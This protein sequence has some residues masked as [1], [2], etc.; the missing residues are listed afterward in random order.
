MKKQLRTQKPG[1]IPG[2]GFNHTEPAQPANHEAEKERQSTT[3]DATAKWISIAASVRMDIRRADHDY[4]DIADGERMLRKEITDA[5]SERRAILV[6]LKKMRDRRGKGFAKDQRRLL[7]NSS[8]LWWLRDERKSARSWLG[9]VRA[10]QLRL[11]QVLT[12]CLR[13]QRST[14]R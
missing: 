11:Q 4:E 6:R 8:D 10:E 13:Q 7:N 14:G 2:R 12:D 3:G 5:L 1:S 9:V